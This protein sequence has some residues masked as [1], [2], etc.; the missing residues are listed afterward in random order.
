MVTGWLSGEGEMASCIYKG[1]QTG[2]GT[3]GTQPQGLPKGTQTT[4]TFKGFNS[5]APTCT[6]T[7]LPSFIGK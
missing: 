7:F 2:A 5:R 1:I 3:W 6:Y 4:D